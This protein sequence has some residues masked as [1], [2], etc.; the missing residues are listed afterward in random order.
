MA[1]MSYIKDNFKFTTGAFTEQNTWLGNYTGSLNSNS[2]SFT[3]YVGVNYAKKYND[4]EVY[5]T[6]HNGLTN[7]NAH[8]DYIAN[9]GPVL[10]YSWSLGA[11]K[12]LDKK[13]SVGFMLYQPVEVYR[14]IAS[15]NIPTGFDSTGNI[16][17]ANSVN[18]AA[19]VKEVRAGGYWKFSDKD[20]SHMLAFLETRQNYQGV[21]GLSET[22]AGISISYK[23]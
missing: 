1:E 3:S 23:F 13:N 4:L 11:E 15:T 8:G 16:M 10:S 22:A 20:N 21:Q 19:T 12:Q 9:V 5:A 2:Q 14:A 7:S 17:Y 6:F 18:L